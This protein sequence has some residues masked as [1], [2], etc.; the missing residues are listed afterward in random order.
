MMTMIISERAQSSK[1]YTNHCVRISVFNKLDGDSFTSEQICSI[2]EHKAPMLCKNTST[3]RP[4]KMGDFR[5]S[6]SSHLSMR[7]SSMCYGKPFHCYTPVGNV[8]SSRYRYNFH[9]ITKSFIFVLS[10]C[11]VVEN[12]FSVILMFKY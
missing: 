8:F 7:K 4:R 5:C 9:I 10:F 12:V 2:I 1:K 6:H 3:E 11:I